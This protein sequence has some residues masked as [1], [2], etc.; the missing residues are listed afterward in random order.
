MTE[1][2]VGMLG[3]TFMGKAHSNA[4]RKVEYLAWPTPLVPRLVA[5]AGRNREA[6]AEAALRYGYERWTTDWHDIITDERIGL[7]DNGGPNS[8]H[9]EPTIAAAEAGKH[10]LCEKPLGRTAD[11]SHDVWRRGAATGVKHLCGFNYRFGPAG[12]L[13]PRAI[14]QGGPGGVPRFPG[15]L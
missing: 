11:E 6:V 2:G 1:I 15:R 8:L 10:V 5:I 13:A 4:F 7:F 12:R 3:Y 14:R 9:A